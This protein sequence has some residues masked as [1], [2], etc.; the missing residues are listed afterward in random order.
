MKT[1]LYAGAVIEMTKRGAT[2][3]DAVHTL[4]KHLERCGMT[5]AM[6]RLRAALEK[7]AVAEMRRGKTVL[8][9][10]DRHHAAH[11]KKEAAEHLNA[12]GISAEDIAVHEDD[13]L[14]GGWRLMGKSTLVDNSFKKHLLSFYKQITR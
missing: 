2:V 9:V 13:S 6:G 7:R 12:L 1:E 5:S 11:A 3:K 8:E 4:A 10:A 14:I